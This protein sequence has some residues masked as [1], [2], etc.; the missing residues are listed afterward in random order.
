L[1]G[2]EEEADAEAKRL[3][4]DLGYHPD[5]RGGFWHAVKGGDGDWRVERVTGKGSVNDGSGG[6]LG[7][8]IDFLVD[9]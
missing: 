2:T 5:G 3:N 4:T 6:I 7:A 8:I 9:W 1:P